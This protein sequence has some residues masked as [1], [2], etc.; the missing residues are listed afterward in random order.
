[1]VTLGKEDHQARIF[2]VLWN[3]KQA[4][5]KAVALD[6][7]TPDIIA[8]VDGKLVAIEVL[9]LVCPEGCKADRDRINSKLER[10]GSLGF[11]RVQVYGFR[12]DYMQQLVD[13]VG[14]KLDH[15]LVEPK[16]R[17]VMR[18]VAE[19]EYGP[20]GEPS[21]GSIPRLSLSEFGHE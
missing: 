4:G 8:V 11:D 3:L 12:E 14:M 9:R 2:E 21:M 13:I 7:T 17:G 18:M 20:A 19:E 15:P 5:H 16:V 6:L 1:M 10:Y